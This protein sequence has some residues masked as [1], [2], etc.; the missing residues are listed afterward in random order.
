MAARS[1]K[2]IT[3]LLVIC[4]AGLVSPARADL[5]PGS[6]SRLRDGVAWSAPRA[7]Q[8]K[9][10]ARRIVSLVPALT[11]MLFA[12]GAG[13]QVVGVGNFE[14]FPPEVKKLPRV[15]ALLDPDTEKILSLRP[16]LVVIYG[17]QTDL[18]QQFT[19]AGITTFVYRHGGINTIFQTMR[20][21]GD[22]TGHRAQADRVVSDLQNRIAS[23][24]ARVKGR[25]KPRVLLVIDRQ[26]KTLREI[27]V[28][29]GVG[30]LH[31]M[32]EAAG[33]TNVFADVPRESAQPSHETLITRAPDVIIE[34]QAEGMIASSDVAADKAVWSSLSSLPAVRTGRI[35]I[36]IGQ[37]LVV[38]GPRFAQATETL[39]R[40]L[41]PDA[42]K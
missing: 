28:S 41:H 38:P 15:G 25:P 11:E 23:V 24:R 33:G 17:S 30:F 31:E 42:F 19:R 39:A 36:L 7:A 34:V 14:T 27:Y 8:E 40:V 21:L 4:G 3:A 10:Q 29:G 1:Q 35:H 12:I 9:T 22:A 6:P 2:L 16:G 32:L 20:E 18:Q 5:T 26:P 13:P 37:Y